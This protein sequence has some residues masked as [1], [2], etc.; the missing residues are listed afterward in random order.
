MFMNTPKQAPFLFSN[1]VFQGL[2]RT[3]K[4]LVY[5][6]GILSLS[7]LVFWV[8]QIKVQ[9][10][11]P[12]QPAVKTPTSEAVLSDTDQ[13]LKNNDTDKDG[14]SDYDEIYTYQT[15]PYLEDSDSDGLS[16]KQEVASGTD[17]NCPVGKTCGGED[18]FLPPATSTAPVTEEPAP[19][20]TVGDQ[21]V[22]KI[23]SGD[24]DGASLRQLLISTGSAKAEDLAGIS[25]AE[26]LASYQAALKNQNQ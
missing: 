3:Q 12:F 15:S 10:E 25:D 6:L 17:P 14:L 4:I 21:D 22:Q 13:I 8:W 11:R 1:S 9:I 23:L 18:V 19:S 24:M 7:I 20:E 16:D 26:L 5:L 2:S